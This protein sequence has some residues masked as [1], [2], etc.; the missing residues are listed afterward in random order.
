[1]IRFVVWG[2]G[3]RG[4][5]AA[6]I[7]GADRIVAFIDSDPAKAGGTFYGKPII[8]FTSYKNEYSD[9]AILVSLVTEQLVT[10][11]LTKEKIF[12]FSYNECPPELMG[13]GW[14]RAKQYINS[15][16][17]PQTK[18]AV[19]GH[20]LY[21]VLVYEFLVNSGYPCVGLVHNPGFS[22]PDIAYFKKFFPSI[23]VKDLDEIDGDT[24]LLQTVSDHDSEQEIHNCKVKN[25]YDWTGFIPDYKNFK[26]A[27]LKDKYKG[28]RCFIVATGPSL[29]FDD[30]EKLNKNHEFCMSLNTIFASFKDTSWRPDQYVVVDVAAINSYDMEI[31]KMDV[32]EKFIADASIDFDYN[33]LTEEFYVFHSVFSKSVLEQGLISEDFSKYAY[34]SGTVTAVCIQLAIYEGFQEIYLLGCDCSY[35]KTGIEH[36]NEPEELRIKKFDMMNDAVK[37]LTYHINAYQKIKNYADKKGIKIYN[38]TRGGYLEVFERIDFDTLFSD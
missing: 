25:I 1:M 23:S 33:S 26:I 27:K 2:A 21:S 36:F 18:M 22:K 38:A 8:D 5:I 11:I 14:Q 6:E 12:F 31:R 4:H 7:F 16:D 10:D 32:K 20:T 35:F 30:L 13:Y 28:K 29:N 19:Y 24:I 9:Y 15:F 37:M 34:N 3:D 17:L